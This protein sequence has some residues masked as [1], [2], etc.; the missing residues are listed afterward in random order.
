MNK[1]KN[2]NCWIFY[3]LLALATCTAANNYCFALIAIVS[4]TRRRN[5]HRRHHGPSIFHSRLLLKI[6][7]SNMHNRHVDSE[8]IQTSKSHHKL[9]INK[10]RSCQKR[11][12]QNNS[13]RL[14]LKKR[15]SHRRRTVHLLSKVR[16]HSLHADP[17]PRCSLKH[18]NFY[19]LIMASNFPKS[20]SDEQALHSYY[21]K[22]ASR[23][24]SPDFTT[25]LPF[26]LSSYSLNCSINC[27]T[28]DLT[29]CGDV[30]RNPGPW[31]VVFIDGDYVPFLYEDLPSSIPVVAGPPPET[32]KVEKKPKFK[33][34]YLS[35]FLNKKHLSLLKVLPKGDVYSRT[36]AGPPQYVTGFETSGAGLDCLFRAF[37]SAY[38]P[39]S[40]A[41]VN[42]CN[43][44]ELRQ[45]LKL[46]KGTMNDTQILQHFLHCFQVN[47]V[48]YTEVE[49]RYFIED[50]DFPWVHLKYHDMHYESVR[51]P[52]AFI[53]PMIEP[54]RAMVPESRFADF[55]M[56]RLP[57]SSDT[58]AP[59]SNDKVDTVEGDI[60]NIIDE[61]SDKT[62]T[63]VSEP[64]VT[65]MVKGTDEVELLENTD[66]ESKAD[67]AFESLS[68]VDNEAAEIDEVELAEG[69]YM[70]EVDEMGDQES[71]AGM[72]DDDIVID[73]ARNAPMI[74]EELPLINLIEIEVEHEACCF[75]LEE[76]NDP[77]A[78]LTLCSKISFQQH[79]AECVYTM[80]DNLTYGCCKFMTI[81]SDQAYLRKLCD[82]WTKLRHELLC[83]F[84]ALNLKV[85]GHS[86]I[87]FHD[88]FPDLDSLRTP[89]FIHIVDGVVYIIEI[90]AVRDIE[91]GKAMKGGFYNI[92]PKY[93]PEIDRLTAA[94]HKT[95]YVPLIFSMGDLYDDEYQDTLKKEPFKNFDL[96][97]I[98]NLR[99]FL[100]NQTRS[101]LRFYAPVMMQVFG[102][103]STYP[104]LFTDY[105]VLRRET[106]LKIYSYFKSVNVSYKSFELLVTNLD[107]L[108]QVASKCRMD[109]YYQIRLEKYKFYLTPTK[110]ELKGVTARHLI[111]LC[112]KKN[113]YLIATF[114]DEDKANQQ[115]VYYRVE[116][117]REITSDYN[118]MFEHTQTLIRSAKFQFDYKQSKE[119]VYSDEN[120]YDLYSGLVRSLLESKLTKPVKMFTNHK[121]DEQVLMDIKIPLIESGGTNIDYVKPAFIYPIAAITDFISY[122]EEDITCSSLMSKI[123]QHVNPFTHKVC[124]DFLSKPLWG[125]IK[126]EQSGR[127]KELKLSYNTAYRHY[128]DYIN[129]E[130]FKNLKLRPKQVIS[131]GG[132]QALVLKGLLGSLNAK[133]SE[134]NRFCNND[135]KMQTVSKTTQLLFKEEMFH[136]K[137]KSS[138]NLKK[139]Y[140]KDPS[141]I[142]LLISWLLLPNDCSDSVM[143][144]SIGED[145][146]L[147]Y[148]LKCHML[149]KD[150]SKMANMMKHYLK[151]NLASASSFVSRLCHTLLYFSQTS[152]NKSYVKIDNLGCSGVVLIMRGGKK[153]FRT[154][155]S[156]FFRLIYP[157]DECFVRQKPDSYQ[158]L[159]DHGRSYFFTP[160]QQLHEAHLI[161][162][163]SFHSRVA[164][165]LC[166]S[167]SFMSDDVELTMRK[168]MI[169]VLLG[170]HNRRKTESG[171]HNMRYMIV[172][173]MSIC[174]DLKTMSKDLQIENTD[175]FT[176]YLISKFNKNYSRLAI[177]L[178]TG[179]K[180]MQ[181]VFSDEFIETDYELAACIYNTYLMTKG[182]YNQRNEQM[183]N[184]HGILENLKEW[185]LTVNQKTPLE[186]HL[187]TNV[188]LLGG[189]IE[190]QQQYI[191]KI[192]ENDFYYDGKLCHLIGQFAADYLQSKKSVGEIEAAWLRIMNKPYDT[193]ANVSGLRGDW[194]DQFFGAKGYE[195][196]YKDFLSKEVWQT[197][198]ELVTLMNSGESDTL[199]LI[200]ADEMIQNS[201]MSFAE[202]LVSYNG[203]CSC[204]A[205]VVDK[206]QRA[207]GREIYVMDLVSKIYQN[208]LELF[209][210]YLC[211][212]YPNELISVPSNE[213]LSKVHS[214]CFES[215]HQ[216]TNMIEYFLSLD[217]RKWAPR[218][219]FNKYWAFLQ[220]FRHILPPSFFN[221]FERLWHSKHDQKIFTKKGVVRGLLLNE[222]YD[223]T[224]LEMF[225]YNKGKII[226]YTKMTAAAEQLRLNEIKLR[227]KK[228]EEDK[229]TLQALM[230]T[231]VFIVMPFS[232]LM[233]LFNF[234]S[235]LMHASCQLFDEH[236]MHKISNE[237]I[238]PETNYP[239][240]VVSH[241]FAHSDDSGGKILVSANGNDCDR[242]IISAVDVHETCMKGANM[243]F[244]PKKSNVSK[245]YFELLSILYYEHR[246]VPLTPKF[247]SSIVFKP[248]DKGY[249]SDALTAYSKS[250]EFFTYG[251]TLG[252]AY[253]VQRLLGYTVWHF[254]FNTEVLECDL[255]RPV[256][257]LGFPDAHPLILLIAGVAGES[258]RFFRKDSKKAFKM[259]EMLLYLSPKEDKESTLPI[260][261]CTPNIHLNKQI[262]RDW[263]EKWE[264][265]K[266]NTSTDFDFCL[267]NV[268]NPN[269]LLNCLKFL[270]KLTDKHFVASL[271][272]ESTVRMMSR[273]YFYRSHNSLNTTTGM[274]TLKEILTFF[275]SLEI[276]VLTEM[277]LTAEDKHVESTK[278]YI[279]NLIS[280]N[281]E[282]I[283]LLDILDKYKF[284]SWKLVR[285]NYSAKPV[286]LHINKFM[287]PII[288]NKY[289]ENVLIYD[290][291]KKYRFLLP[292]VFGY[293]KQLLLVQD[294]LST[295]GIKEI[296]NNTQ[297]KVLKRLSSKN[298][299]R[300][301]FY[302]YMPSD[303]RFI[304]D[305]NG[306]LRLLSCNSF[307]G[308]EVLGFGIPAAETL[309]IPQ[310]NFESFKDPIFL[311]AFAYLTFIRQL[312]NLKGDSLI[313]KWVLITPS[314][315]TSGTTCMSIVKQIS[316]Y[317]SNN[318]VQS[319]ILY[320]MISTLSSEVINTDLFVR[321]SAFFFYTRIQTYS[322]YRYFGIG[323]IMIIIASNFYILNF[324][325]GSILRI[326][327]SHEVGLMHRDIIRYINGVL[328]HERLPTLDASVVYRTVEDEMCF[329]YNT[330]GEW[331]IAD[332]RTLKCGIRLSL[333]QSADTEMGLINTFRITYEPSDDS[334][335]L[336][337]TDEF[338]KKLDIPVHFLNPDPML[339]YSQVQSM[340]SK[341][342]VNVEMLGGK[343]VESF[344]KDELTYTKFKLTL[345]SKEFRNA[346]ISS[347]VYKMVYKMQG[348][349]MSD[350]A[351]WKIDREHRLYPGENGTFLRLCYEY[352][353]KDPKFKFDVPESFD[354]DFFL[355]KSDKSRELISAIYTNSLQMFKSIYTAKEQQLIRDQL[356]SLHQSMVTN[357]PKFTQDALI[358][359]TKYGYAG[360]S[361]ALQTITTGND[362]GNFRL[363]RF[364]SVLSPQIFT[365]CFLNLHF[366]IGN[367]IRG[368]PHL[369][370]GAVKLADRNLDSYDLKKCFSDIT[371]L[372]ALGWRK[373]HS[374]YFDYSSSSYNLMPQ[375]FE[376]IM[377]CHE[378]EFNQHLSGDP[379]LRR[380]PFKPENIEEVMIFYNFLLTCYQDIAGPTYDLRGRSPMFQFINDRWK[381]LGETGS[382]VR[383]SRIFDG[384]RVFTQA[385]Y[386][387]TKSK[388]IS[389]F[390]GYVPN[391]IN[392]LAYKLGMMNMPQDEWDEFESEVTMAEVDLSAIENF[393]KYSLPEAKG[394]HITVKIVTALGH[395]S[396]NVL[397]YVMN[398]S[399]DCIVITDCYVPD[400]KLE[401]NHRLFLPSKIMDM[402]YGLIFA[403]TASISNKLVLQEYLL[404]MGCEVAKE[405]E[406]TYCKKFISFSGQITEQM[407]AMSQE[408]FDEILGSLNTDPIQGAIDFTTYIKAACLKLLPDDRIRRNYEKV[409]LRPKEDNEGETQPITLVDA[410]FNLN[411]AKISEDGE[412]MT[413]M[414][415]KLV[416][417]SDSIQYSQMFHHMKYLSGVRAEKVGEIKALKNEQ[418]RAELECISIGL[419]NALL[420]DKLSISEKKKK[421]MLSNCRM[422][423]KG[424]LGTPYQTR[425][426]FFC[427]T[428]MSLLIKSS[429][430]GDMSQDD[431]NIWSNISDFYAGLDPEE[432]D[433]DDSGTEFEPAGRLV[434]ELK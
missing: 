245:R 284:K 219:V 217:C 398:L 20:F 33:F 423:L 282:I 425:N 352:R 328:L 327:T 182:Q 244:S 191:N 178:H 353:F 196:V 428:L 399:N 403:Y 273:S 236:L 104:F 112:I 85:S 346:Y 28:P 3:L 124:N 177:S 52:P 170:F 400:E 261:N 29:I 148:E 251:A 36:I 47:C 233:G 287:E 298:V 252:E 303:Y 146:D 290:K 344:L 95:H 89:D 14:S 63:E 121:V 375:V 172:N 64:N 106:K 321:N 113:F 340:L 249:V 56:G 220:P 411:M 40:L 248:T 78:L 115:T 367:V 433:S 337:K 229:A 164:G 27:F 405:V 385:N 135:L 167:H 325:S 360:V 427:N 418:L 120:Y 175:A 68:E 315:L 206:V 25:L 283:Q 156:K 144:E 194:Q 374:S 267:D 347:W 184:L 41:M 230:S 401:G 4:Y 341:D 98:E 323:Q 45:I 93:A 16:V 87:K 357:D 288:L 299:K 166:L 295:K 1:N 137:D 361:G 69:E 197:I 254:Y 243:L 294:Y 132:E 79:R 71:D 136:Y 125:S 390:C 110:N 336:T 8:A 422:L 109:D 430:L 185:L 274:R 140:C 368:L 250:I 13:R 242:N 241:L 103:I 134:Y 48:L 266:G 24:H 392:P 158:I 271:Q 338:G 10:A 221:L 187:H 270:N 255:N 165:Y 212:Q 57:S 100:L 356:I 292:D 141:W 332:S 97:G 163:L 310:I 272:D 215:P 291:F 410:M 59:S 11:V 421:T 152:F 406:I 207:G 366:A 253:F 420:S 301:K 2:K 409:V 224:N 317:F 99:R 73:P 349:E 32:A 92:L 67:I 218:S 302:S 139:V 372:Y 265:I 5:I 387:V 86:D 203:V 316:V 81:H 365:A 404:K 306:V 432:S 210:A 297:L 393:R 300:M 227:G 176:T 15:G 351:D 293:E 226:K 335:M 363:F 171:L 334:Y 131:N 396:Y 413:S 143:P 380:L 72:E 127:L 54:E 22:L 189:T 232:W 350:G 376:Y 96:I 153:I 369:P 111:E 419:T 119:S 123:N 426:E 214:K 329:G 264:N 83:E 159:S 77:S 373:R 128:Y 279:A 74:N 216:L 377:N 231:P 269:S 382:I 42:K 168:L 19:P 386:Q 105:D 199:I 388:R 116:G 370:K 320:P 246:L 38:L 371:L 402:T 313:D 278:A 308:H 322:H 318:Y 208:P 195:T 319:C 378:A 62:D 408:Q 7:S 61:D 23:C 44:D 268:Q 76:F 66:E 102:D 130:S 397:D 53:V 173:A 312:L 364:H 260:L 211:K 434:Y 307:R 183:S 213:R 154:K 407:D 431:I 12:T 258:L 88:V 142:D 237:I 359:L 21:N 339:V 381:Q 9:F 90:S 281:T 263:V 37:F 331:E 417:E 358:I 82:G 51:Y 342:I 155:N 235:S 204:V 205:H 151:T 160:W 247:F 180:V 202:K 50:Y 60:T 43:F 46:E 424:S 256:H 259:I 395:T 286:E 34:G 39:G 186:Q 257:C 190:D 289:P 70:D 412:K 305:Y 35:E 101:F 80:F 326:I 429:R 169:N 311:E 91:K 157:V 145:A 345:D 26:V 379:I 383:L 309:T 362:K 240:T 192:F 262:L 276:P 31:T 107:N 150:E 161:D 198:Q 389:C 354:R 200:K 285:Q 394:E 277:Y 333:S 117:E 415:N 330:F 147:L 324:D 162:G 296:S 280:T 275:R 179:A 414:I 6:R 138:A 193:I 225:E 343:S 223:Y 348:Q 149:D 355:L 239:L 65:D 201:N 94:G 118:P 228:T 30:E 55:V 222:R 126:A 122:N 18:R 384:V 238:D 129:S 209:F 75:R 181:Q 304:D 49:T 108:R 84:V 114:I 174:S 58:R 17:S 416:K 188:E 234:L 314:F 133:A 391:S